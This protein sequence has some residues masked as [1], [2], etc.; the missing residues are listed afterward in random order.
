MKTFKINLV[1]FRLNLVY[2]ID[3]EKKKTK[4]ERERETTRERHLERLFE[5]K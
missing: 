1:F 5:E 2:R 3:S 4:F